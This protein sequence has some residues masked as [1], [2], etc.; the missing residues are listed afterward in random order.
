MGPTNQTTVTGAPAST[1]DRLRMQEAAHEALVSEGTIS[2]YIADG[3]F[4]SWVV[5][6]PGLSRGFDM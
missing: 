2:N 4:D 6:R 5:K 1:R 3:L